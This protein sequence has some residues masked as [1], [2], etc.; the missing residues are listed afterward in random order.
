MLDYLA[1][2]S[3]NGA[4]LDGLVIVRDGKLVFEHY[5]P[6]Y[7]GDIPHQLNSVTKSFVST[8]VGIAQGEGKIGPVTTPVH[9]LLK[10]CRGALCDSPATLKD[11]LTMS[12]GLEW[13]E[14]GF[15]EEEDPSKILRSADWRRYVLDKPMA[16]APGQTFVYNSGGSHLLSLMLQ[17]SLGG[18]SEAAFADDRLFKP[19]GISDYHWPVDPQGAL[20]GGRGLTLRLDDLA[21]FGQLFLQNGQWQGKQIVPATWVHDATHAQIKTVPPFGWV[22]QYGYQWWVDGSGHNYSAQGW[23]GQVL[24]VAPKLGMVVAMLTSSDANGNG[25]WMTP[26]MLEQFFAQELK[27]QGPIPLDDAGWGRLQQRLAAMAPKPEKTVL[28]AWFKRLDGKTAQFSGLG[29]QSKPQFRLD[30]DGVQIVADYRNRQQQDRATYSYGLGQWRNFDHPVYGPCV[31]KLTVS[32]DKVQLRARS[33]REG[34]EIQTSYRMQ[35]AK[36]IE[37]VSE[38]GGNAVSE[39]AV[40]L[41]AN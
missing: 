18:E 13:Y 7:R 11:V 9:A 17:D 22:P 19:L 28:P 30:A 16:E 24:I 20:I 32:G 36:R 8:L 2:V 41:I 6:P 12:S 33:L 1:M 14:A 35:D 31:G 21:R 27:W 25:A 5:T 40:G 15:S 37:S 26:D 38:N 29:W 39:R 3:R 10:D 23:G 4:S 34:K